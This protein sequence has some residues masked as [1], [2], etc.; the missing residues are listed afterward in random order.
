MAPGFQSGDAEFPA[1]PKGWFQ[2]HSCSWLSGGS[3]GLPPPFLALSDPDLSFLRPGQQVGWRRG[4]AL[5]GP[6]H[7]TPQCVSFFAAGSCLMV[8]L[9]L[10][11]RHREPGAQGKHSTKWG[12]PPPTWSGLRIF[13]NWMCFK[14]P[15]TLETIN[16]GASFTQ[17]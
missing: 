5:W 12:S 9:L 11:C 17:N 16:I 6:A 8:H 7:E 2:A 14:N 3:S 4:T 13:S 10:G 1:W 15:E